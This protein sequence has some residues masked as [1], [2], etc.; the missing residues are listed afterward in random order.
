VDPDQAFLDYEESFLDLLHGELRQGW[1]RYETRLRL[2]GDLHPQRTFAQPAW[3]GAPF[4]GKTLLL[5]AEQGLGDTLM[6]VRYLPMVKALGGRVILEAQ[7]AL[8]ALAATCGGADL[9][10][11]RGAPL[12]AFD[13]QASLLSLPWL[14]RTDLASI[15]AEIPYLNVPAKVTHRQALLD[16]LTQAQEC[17]RIG[18]VWA[19]SPGHVRDA[20][21]SLPVSALAPLAALPGVAW[22]SFQLGRTEV[23]PLPGLIPLAPWLQDFSDTAY[24][25]SGMDLVITVDTSVA[26]LAGAMGIPTLLLLSFQPDFRWLLKRD[27]TPWYPSLRLYRQPTYGDW[28]SVVQQV[29]RDLTQDP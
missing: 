11:P 18:L 28:T 14:F 6:F 22:F 13:L 26:H 1:E 7:P 19:G 23:P 20:E 4:A 2:P 29:V 21:R 12:P 17:S 24:A 16:L 5:W 9:L 10:V 25:L 15:P 8:M 3:N 27:D